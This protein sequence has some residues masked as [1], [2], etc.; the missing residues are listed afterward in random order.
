MSLVGLNVDNED[1]RVAVLDKLHGRLGGQGV[2]D[3]GM[4]TKSVL[5]W[6]AL[7]LVLGLSG[8]L[9]SLGLVEVNLCVDSGSLLGDALL[10]GFCDC[11]CFLG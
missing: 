5:S 2:L 4:V 3:D 8:V 10:Q 7:V 6:C 11:G 1:K 9:K